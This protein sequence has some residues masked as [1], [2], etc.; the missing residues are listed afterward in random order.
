MSQS[1]PLESTFAPHT[2]TILALVAPT[3]S[4][5]TELAIE[6]ATALDAEI[7]SIDSLSIYKHINIA[8]AKPSQKALSQI[9]H[10]A[11][12]VLEPSEHCSAEVFCTLFAQALQACQKEF[13]LIVGGSGFYLSCLYEGLSAMPRLSQEEQVGIEERIRNL[14][15]PYAFLAD[16]DPQSAQSIAPSDTYR[17][18]KLLSIYFATQLA[19]SVYFATHTRSPLIPKPPIYTIHTPKPELHARI[20][21]RTKAML[22]SGLLD[23]ARFLLENYGRSIQPFKAIGLKECLDYFDGELESSELEPL[24]ATHT[25]Q[26]AKRQAT[27]IRAKFPSAQVESSEKLYDRIMREI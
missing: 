7:F 24:I 4:G 17:V 21:A 13:L 12:N 26:L 27:Y 16:I 22:D 5:K 15:S 11:I 20:E 19:P 8:S 9:P 25:R 14:A 10:H 6:L 2:P 23:E 18:Q 3:A 1:K